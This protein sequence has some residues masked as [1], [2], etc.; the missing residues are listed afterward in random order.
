MMMGRSDCHASRRVL[1]A[2]TIRPAA[3]AV[4]PSVLAASATIAR[5][6]I[7]EARKILRR[8]LV[9]P[10]A[11][12]AVIRTAPCADR[13]TVRVRRAKGADSPARGLP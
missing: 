8:G 7:V 11:C 3:P 13:M 6:R 10:V 1:A 4:V 2:R 12:S 5:S 9:F